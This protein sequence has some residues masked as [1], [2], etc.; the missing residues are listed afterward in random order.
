MQRRVRSMEKTPRIVQPL[1]F[2]SFSYSFSFFFLLSLPSPGLGLWPESLTA[3]ALLDR[4]ARALVRLV[5][6]RTESEL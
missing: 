5:G 3:T 2:F 4:R 6:F 1:Y